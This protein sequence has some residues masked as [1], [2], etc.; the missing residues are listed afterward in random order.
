MTFYG[1]IRNRNTGPAYEHKKVPVPHT[2]WL[3]HRINWAPRTRT[4]KGTGRGAPPTNTES[5]R[6]TYCKIF[7]P[8]KSVC[9]WVFLEFNVV[10]DC[11]FTVWDCFFSQ[12]FFIFNVALIVFFTVFFSA[13]CCSNIFFTACCLFFFPHL[14]MLHH[15]FSLVSHEK[16]TSFIYSGKLW[17]LHCVQVLPVVFTSTL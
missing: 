1:R 7:G 3:M 13:F 17:F 10:W 5:C 6:S 4:Q 9:F 16:T 11:F 8:P 15:V 2:K 14:R 12:F